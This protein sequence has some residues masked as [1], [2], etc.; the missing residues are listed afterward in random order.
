MRVVLPAPLAPSSPVT[1]RPTVKVAPLSTGVAPHRFT[2]S[3]ISITAAPVDG[4]DP[5]GTVGARASDTA[6]T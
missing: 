1:P 5:C 3:V 2:T 6:A 4:A